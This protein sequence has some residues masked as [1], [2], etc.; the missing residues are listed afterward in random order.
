MPSMLQPQLERMFGAGNVPER[1]TRN[2]ETINTMMDRGVPI[3]NNTPPL[4]G[5]EA[6]NAVLTDYPNLPPQYHGIVAQEGYDR[7]LYLDGSGYITG[8]VGQTGKFIGGSPAPVIKEH[9]DRAKSLFKTYTDYPTSIQSAL[10]DS[11]YRGDLRNASGKPQKWTG[12]A[13]KGLWNEAADE[14]L[15]NDNYYESKGLKK[16]RTTGKFTKIDVKNPG[17]KQRFEERADAMRAY[18]EELK[19][20]EAPVQTQ[21]ATFPSRSGV[22]VIGSSTMAIPPTAQQDPSR[23]Y[24]VAKGDTLSQIAR[25]S[26]MTVDQLVAHNGISNPDQIQV[27]QTIQLVP[28]I[29]GLTSTG[30]SSSGRQIYDITDK[31]PKSTKDTF[32]TMWSTLF[33]D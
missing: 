15:D 16:N 32:N 27:G 13:N 17:L 29:K 20:A 6:L 21:D 26:G 4:H 22:P 30:V 3:V 24:Q 2:A 19:A 10:I 28:E 12:L 31:I 9:E 25:D 8:G 33:G 7:D 5:P 11:A 1:N 23:T 14:H 18:G